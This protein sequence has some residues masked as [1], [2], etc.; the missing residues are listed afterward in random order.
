V[1]GVILVSNHFKQSRRFLIQEPDQLPAG[2]LDLRCRQIGP[3]TFPQCFYGLGFFPSRH[4]KDNLSSPIQDRKGQGNPMD[5]GSSAFDRRY[6]SVFFPQCAR[7]RKERS[8]VA[9]LAHPKEDEIKDGKF[10]GG[11][12]KKADEL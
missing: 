9:V 1:F 12:L 2:R 4:Q 8:R 6:H 3:I 10:A 11:G 7:P 5:V